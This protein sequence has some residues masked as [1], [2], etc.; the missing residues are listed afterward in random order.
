MSCYWAAFAAW[1]QAVVLVLTSPLSVNVNLRTGSDAARALMLADI[2][3][4]AGYLFV[5]ITPPR[6]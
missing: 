6:R 3:S 1:H 2:T 4:D 5:Q